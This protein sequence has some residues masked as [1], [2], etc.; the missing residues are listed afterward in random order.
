MKLIKHCS[1]FLALKNS[2][3]EV[4]INGNHFRPGK[5]L[6]CNKLLAFCFLREEQFVSV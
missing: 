5:L 1:V 2:I 4:M 3:N 6:F